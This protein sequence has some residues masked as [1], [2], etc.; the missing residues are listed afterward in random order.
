LRQC[1]TGL[2]P[3]PATKFVEFASAYASQHVWFFAKEKHVSR[4]KRVDLSTAKSVEE[5]RELVALA[6]GVDPA[7]IAYGLDEGGLDIAAANAFIENAIGTHAFVYAVVP[8]VK[9]N[10]RD[11]TVPFVGDASSGELVRRLSEAA[12]LVNDA[13]GLHATLVGQSTMAAQIQLTDVRDL[14][15]AEAAIVA[16]T[17][18]ILDI[19][20]NAIPSLAARGGGAKGVSV[21]RLDDDEMLVVHVSVDCVDAMGANLVNTVAEA[22]APRLTELAG[23]RMGLR[24]LSNLSDDRRASVS[25]RLPLETVSSATGP[26]SRRRIEQLS[27]LDTYDASFAEAHNKAVMDAV[28]GV[29]MATGNDW[30]AVEAGAHAFAARH[31][32]YQSL[33]RWSFSSSADDGSI[34][35]VLD[36][37]LALGTVGGTLRTHRAAQLSLRILG[38]ERASDLALVTASLGLLAS[39]AFVMKTIAR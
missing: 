31:G 39:F 17:G 13:G 9:I 27:R 1:I 22:V 20:N 8:C 34:V 10:D 6:I 15:S 23:G 3:T 16:A 30:R 33:A 4:S 19:A 28:D 12:G 2:T 7:L 37:P 5:R 11:F 14:D 26:D 38:V 18:Q 35:G 29:V 24:I 21:R 25:C 32:T 36:L